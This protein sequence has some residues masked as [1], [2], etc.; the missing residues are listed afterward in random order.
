MS[1]L[2]IRNL[3]AN[4]DGTEILR[5]IDLTVE[6]GAVHAVNQAGRAGVARSK[7]VGEALFEGGAQAGEGLERGRQ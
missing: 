6:P 2:E 1:L 3:H 7:L 5:G 4:I